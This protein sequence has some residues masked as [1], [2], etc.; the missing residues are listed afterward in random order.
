MDAY[1]ILMT[2][3]KEAAVWVATSKDIPGLVLESGSF[4]ALVERVKYAVPELMELNHRK[5]S[6]YNLNFT[7]ERNDM[8]QTNG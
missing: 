4:D 6:Y 7:S 2:W 3:D 8:V 1:N 5:A